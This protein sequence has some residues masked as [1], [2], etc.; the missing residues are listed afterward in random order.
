MA[1]TMLRQRL[2]MRSEA[3]YGVILRVIG[4]ELERRGFA[5]FDMEIQGDDVCVSVRANPSGREGLQL[6][7]VPN[8]QQ[9][10]L[11]EQ[12]G[13]SCRRAKYPQ[14]ENYVAFQLHYTMD[15]L[16]RLDQEARAK[17]RNPDRIPS[18]YSMSEILR[19]IGTFVVHEKGHLRSLSLRNDT[20]T[21]VYNTATGRRTIEL[22]AFSKRAGMGR[23]AK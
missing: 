10:G 5:A 22:F 2:V 1:L 7:D 18:S 14:Q 17:R 6:G 12:R 13:T 19:A 15:E 20:V 8:A 3:N 23:K 21:V 16:K 11:W 4:Q 9:A